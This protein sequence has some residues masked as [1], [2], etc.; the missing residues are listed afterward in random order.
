MTGRIILALFA[1]VA[2]AIAGCSSDSRTASSNT[3]QDRVSDATD[4]WVPTIRGLVQEVITL[5]LEPTAEGAI[6]QA[7]GLPLRQGFYDS[8]LVPV[9]PEGADDDVLSFEFR[10]T[11]P[12]KRT[13]AGT[14][15]SREV[16][17][18]TSISRRALA[19]VTMIRVISATNALSVRP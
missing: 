15:I 2:V 10:I 12:P 16:L 6:I 17:A 9:K 13:P 3:G 5:K 7:A 4:I 8:E 1:A 18:A 11:S 19:E 14:P